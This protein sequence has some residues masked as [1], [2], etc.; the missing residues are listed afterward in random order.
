MRAFVKERRDSSLIDPTEPCL[1]WVLFGCVL[2]TLR[3]WQPELL[4]K[5]YAN[6][7]LGC[8][9]EL[10][11]VKMWHSVPKVTNECFPNAPL[12]WVLSIRIY[13]DRGKSDRR[14][15]TANQA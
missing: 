2:S 11:L 15:L 10:Q 5:H 1:T 4:S 13:V 8:S 3:P 14:P 6:N 9:G 12:Q 7:I